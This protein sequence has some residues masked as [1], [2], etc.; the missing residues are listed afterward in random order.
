MALRLEKSNINSKPARG[1]GTFGLPRKAA[2]SPKIG[3]PGIRIFRLLCQWR[4]DDAIGIM[5]GNRHVI[6]D[7]RV[8]TILIIVSTPILQLFAR[9]FKR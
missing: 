6:S 2:L 7:C 3:P 5:Q 4:A 8:R 9:I 1:A